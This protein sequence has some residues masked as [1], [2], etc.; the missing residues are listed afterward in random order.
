M[1]AELG[2]HGLP[3][4]DSHFATHSPVVVE[5]AKPCGLASRD[6]LR[7]EVC[8]PLYG[9]ELNESLT[10]LDAALKWTVKMDKEN[11]IAKESLKNYNPLYRLVKLTLEKGI[12]RE[13]YDVLNAG[14][15][16]IGKVTSGT[17][18]VTLG[19][20]IALALVQKDKMPQD[21]IFKIRIRNKVYEANFQSKPFVI[22][23]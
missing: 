19:K 2:P 1:H 11:F 5:G 20:G 13:N 9:H 15:E 21:K 18:S 17:L 10:P 6:V 23:G 22:K 14:E 8:Y 3:A 16:T 7:L 4:R 12:P